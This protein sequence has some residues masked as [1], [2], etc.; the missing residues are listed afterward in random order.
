MCGLY[1]GRGARVQLHTGDF[2]SKRGEDGYLQQLVGFGCVPT[3]KF[4]QAV[5]TSGEGGG[6]VWTARTWGLF[7]LSLEIIPTPWLGSL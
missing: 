7:G 3:T 5:Q 4:L 2:M 1:L 6:C